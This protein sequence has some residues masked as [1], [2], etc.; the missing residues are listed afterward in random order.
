[1]NVLLVYDCGDLN[2][3]FFLVDNPTEE[4]LLFLGEAN[5]KYVNSDDFNKGMGFLSDAICDTPSYC[6]NPEYACIWADKEIRTPLD[7]KID[8]VY[9]S[10][11]CP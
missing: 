7:A 1:M 8:K 3:K 6:E 11:M 10:G 4:Q 5:G 2:I 9:Y